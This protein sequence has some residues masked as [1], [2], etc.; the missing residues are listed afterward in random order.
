MI[1]R[2]SEIEEYKEVVDDSVGS[3]TSYELPLYKKKYL[4]GI[5]NTVLKLTLGG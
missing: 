2:K 5:R 4:V 3:T 1:R